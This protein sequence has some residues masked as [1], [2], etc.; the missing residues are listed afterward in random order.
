MYSQTCQRSK[1]GGQLFSQNASSYMFDRLLIT[2]VDDTSR[3][4]RLSKCVLLWSVFIVLPIIRNQRKT[5]TISH[6][7]LETFINSNSRYKTQKVSWWILWTGDARN[8]H[9]R[10]FLS[11]IISEIW[12][13]LSWL[14]LVLYSVIF[15]NEKRIAKKMPTTM[16]DIARD[17]RKTWKSEKYKK[18]LTTA[19]NLF[20]FIFCV[21]EKIYFAQ[22]HSLGKC[23]LY[24]KDIWNVVMKHQCPYKFVFVL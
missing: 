16:F 8:V 4:D 1:H 24:Y 22:K 12:G 7:D 10:F 13:Y 14:S 15:K 2:L 17:I 23:I 6:I 19:I 18:S 3:L 9:N 21:W 5:E 20:T 11:N